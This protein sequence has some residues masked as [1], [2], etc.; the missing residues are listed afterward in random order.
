M[1]F[2]RRLTSTNSQ[3][4]F[5][6]LWVEGERILVDLELLLHELSRVVLLIQLVI[7]G[8]VFLFLTS[9]TIELAVQNL[10]NLMI[11]HNIPAGDEVLEWNGHQLQNATFD[12]VYE[13]INS[14]KNDVQVELIVSR[15]TRFYLFFSVSKRIA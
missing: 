4:V 14:S 3:E 8:Q 1:N 6:R 12:Q 10:A 2:D 7:C 5:F 11:C 15:S 13:I 9:L